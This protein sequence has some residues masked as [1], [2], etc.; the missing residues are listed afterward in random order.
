M[1]SILTTVWRRSEFLGIGGAVAGN[2]GPEGTQQN[3]S[4]ETDVQAPP[5]KAGAATEPRTKRSEN[6][7]ADTSQDKQQKPATCD[8]PSIDKPLSYIHGEMTQN[9]DSEPAEKIRNELD[10]E[11]GDADVFAL[12]DDPSD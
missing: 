2:S 11:I 9:V 1:S 3:Q 7:N 4:Q 12:L 8:Y 10:V 5:E 6:R